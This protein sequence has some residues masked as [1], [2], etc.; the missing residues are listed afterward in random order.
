MV[1][2]GFALEC[3]EPWRLESR[4]FPS[5]IGGKPAWLDLK[6]IPGKSELECEYCGDPC[7]FLCQIY[8]PYDNPDTFHRTIYIFICK[9]VEC[10]KSNQNGNLKVFRSQL[11]KHNIFYS[12][13]PPIEKKDWETDVDVSKWTKTC[14]ICGILAPFHCSKCKVVNYCFR[15]HQVHDWKNGH[16]KRCSIKV[17][18]VNERLCKDND[19]LFPE[20]E[21]TI[22][23]EE[24]DTEDIENEQKELEKYNAMIRDNI[25]GTLQNEDVDDD[26][27]QMALDEKDQVFTEFHTKVQKHPDQVLRYNRGGEVL[28]I[29]PHNQV[30][31]VPKCSECNGN[32]QFEFQIMPQLL[33]YLG[34]TDFNCLDWGILAVFT[35]EQSC[36]PNNKYIR[37]Y[38]WKQDIVQ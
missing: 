15:T 32:R 35:C 20:Y 16:K 17:D 37:E 9:N 8:A 29:S 12:P 6:N 22:D 27:L 2:L 30:T 5:K 21:I 3:C 36:K 19:I 24:L 31:N 25:A 10:C 34:S 4:F 13:K 18:S 26:L 28:Y 11:N 14:H 1:D 33:H 7:I 38:I 23:T